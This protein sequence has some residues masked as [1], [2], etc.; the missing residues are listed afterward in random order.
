M[1]VLV[2]GGTGFL[3][4][5]VRNELEKTNE[6]DVLYTSRNIIDLDKNITLGNILDPNRVV[7][8]YEYFQPDAILHMAASCG[9]ILANK[10][11]PAEFL[12]Q[13]IQMGLNIFNGIV[14][15]KQKNKEWNPLVYTLGSVCSYPKYCSV[16]F[17]EDSI[18][19][20]YPEETNAPYGHAKKTL[21]MLQDIYREQ[22]GIRGAH[23]I[24][25]N[26]YGKFDQ[27]DPVNSHVIPAMIRKVY[28]AK[29]NQRENVEL[30]GSG[31]VTREFLYAED[32]AK[33]L[34]QAIKMELN[35]A[36]PINLGTGNDISIIELAQLI[37]T[38]MDYHGDLVFLNNGLDGQPKRRLD[39]S[40][41][42]SVFGFDAET[43]LED[44]LR[45]TI[46]WYEG[47]QL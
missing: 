14:K 43:S 6:F 39:V 22:Y 13:N 19:N 38:I 24:L 1:K 33:Y 18:W 11:S 17:K 47:E 34:V 23:L 7:E 36:L 3:G 12:S 31:Q 10:N 16:P 42:K 8:L 20:G 15:Y 35:Y 5:N 21:L 27:F 2:T 26:L 32:C 46:A 30:W 41:A 40:R 4:K 44:G 29:K 28:F 37:V 9:G 45:K 25:A